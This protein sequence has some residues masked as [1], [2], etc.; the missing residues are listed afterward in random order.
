MNPIVK[1]NIIDWSSFGSSNKEKEELEKGKVI[2]GNSSSLHFTLENLQ[3]KDSQQDQNFQL[4]SG[5]STPRAEDRTDYVASEKAFQILV[6]Q[7]RIVKFFK[8]LKINSD[9]AYELAKEG[10]DIKD[11]NGITTICKNNVPTNDFDKLQKKVIYFQDPIIEF[12]K[13]INET[14]TIEEGFTTFFTDFKGKELKQ[15]EESFDK[16]NSKDLKYESSLPQI[17][18]T[19]GNQNTNFYGDQT[20]FNWGMQTAFEIGAARISK[21]WGFK[22]I[23]FFGAYARQTIAIKQNRPE[24]W[25]EDGNCEYGVLRGG[26]FSGKGDKRLT[27]VDRETYKELGKYLNDQ[28]KNLT[29]SDE[30]FFSDFEIFPHGYAVKWDLFSDGNPVL[31]Y[32]VKVRD[33]NAPKKHVALNIYDPNFLDKKNNIRKVVYHMSPNDSELMYNECN[34]LFNEAIKIDEEE[35]LYRKLGEL[36]WLTCQAKFWSRGDPAIAEIII[37]SILMSKGFKIK[38]WDKNIIPWVE[39][40]KKPSAYEFGKLFLKLFEDT[41]N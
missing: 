2:S 6:Q 31:A 30:N 24:A 16:I 40:S 29:L 4:S 19:Y 20:I 9:Q 14:S 26:P 39:V 5:E 32:Y 38:S 10:Y 18:N 35:S 41:K 37:K 23:M 12:I 3:L 7:I 8:N 22:E 11:I 1:N 21:G 36:Y 34:I 15:W 13:C 25:D 28:Y 33:E 27:W 17:V